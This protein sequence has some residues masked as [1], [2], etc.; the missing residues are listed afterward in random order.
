MAEIEPLTDTIRRFF[1]LPGCEV[2]GPLHVVIED[3]NVEDSNLSYCLCEI[4]SEAGREYFEGDWDTMAPLA[5]QIVARLA[6]L[7]AD[8]R[9]RAVRDGYP[10]RV[11]PVLQE[12]HT[13]PPVDPTKERLVLDFT[14]PLGT[15]AC[16]RMGLPPM[17]ESLRID[18]LVEGEPTTVDVCRFC[19]AERAPEML[20]E[21]ERGMTDGLSFD[22]PS[23]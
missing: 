18:V 14:T 13:R 11:P 9:H 6:L 20:A 12:R 7:P 4:L 2:G 3:E 19:M 21:M 17:R 23:V 8:E 10:P 1:A 15:C 16:C 22:D 5:V